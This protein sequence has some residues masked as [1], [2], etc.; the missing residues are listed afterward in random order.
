MDEIQNTNEFTAAQ[1]RPFH[2]SWNGPH[3]GV[4]RDMW[5]MKV[6]KLAI[7]GTHLV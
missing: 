7:L 4:N 2:I 1:S 6:H 5:A 3:S